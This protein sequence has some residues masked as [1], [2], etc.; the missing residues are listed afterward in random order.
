MTDK[1]R[2][3]VLRTGW[4]IGGGLLVAAAGATA[5]EALRPLTSVASGRVI[6]AGKVTDFQDGTAKYLPE[7]RLYVVNANN[8]LFA[9]SQ[10]CP[11][12]GCRVPFCD[13]SGRFECPCHGSVFDLAGEHIKGPAPRGMDRF[14]VSV[15]ANNKVIVD[16]NVV[17]SGPD[18]GANAFLTPAKGP[19]CQGKS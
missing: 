16:T 14:H 19:A 9:L 17:T 18:P 11:H 4:K 15:D 1:T 10:K 12:L 3:E 2:R 6:E 7:G 5:Y 8:N 13:S